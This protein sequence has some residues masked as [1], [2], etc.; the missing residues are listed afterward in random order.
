[1]GFWLMNTAKQLSLCKIRVH[2]WISAHQHKCKRSHMS[3]PLYARI[4]CSITF[5]E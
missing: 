2:T 4:I 5:R 3:R 1:L